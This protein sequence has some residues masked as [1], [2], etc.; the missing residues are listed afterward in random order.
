MRKI[1]AVL[2]FLLFLAFPSASASDG[3]P[4]KDANAD[5]QPVKDS[6]SFFAASRITRISPSVI[7]AWESVYP[8]K[9]PKYPD[10]PHTTL[11]YYQIDCKEQT[12]GLVSRS[13]YNSNGN[14]IYH[15]DFENSH[16]SMNKAK[17]GSHDEALVQT[18]CSHLNNTIPVK[19]KRLW[20]FYQK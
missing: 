7:R 9:Y 13:H 6:N 3:N 14:R 16:I 4:L 11:L 2:P 17:P 15:A 12:V 1:F 18:A 19:K 5:W 10:L 20:D 8:E